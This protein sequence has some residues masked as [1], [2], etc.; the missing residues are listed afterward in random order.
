MVCYIEYV[1]LDNFVIDYLLLKAAFSVTGKTV[2]KLR[3]FLAAALGAV[4]APLFP[5]IDVSAVIVFFLKLLI[6]LLLP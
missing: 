5:L 3:L 4:T 6:I 1:L 2:K